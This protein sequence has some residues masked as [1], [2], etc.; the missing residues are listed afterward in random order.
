MTPYEDLLTTDA[1]LAL[2]QLRLLSI[3]P[4]PSMGYEQFV[5]L[6]ELRF[7]AGLEVK[8]YSDVL[9]HE[10]LVEMAGAMHAD[11][12]ESLPMTDVLIMCDDAYADDP[13]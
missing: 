5:R 2:T 8:L 3:S 12:Q 4:S 6:A 13:S 10:E 9:H 11:L 7:L 1:L